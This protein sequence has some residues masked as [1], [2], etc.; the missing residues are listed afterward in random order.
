MWIS[1]VESKFWNTW[2]WGGTWSPNWFP[3]IMCGTWNLPLMPG[4]NSSFNISNQHTGLWMDPQWR[5]NGMCW[6][7]EIYTPHR[8]LL[9]GP[10]DVCR[11]GEIGTREAPLN[12]CRWEMLGGF[13]RINCRGGVLRY[14]VSHWAVCKAAW[15]QRQVD[16]CNSLTKILP[17]VWSLWI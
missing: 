11:G 16:N 1:D 4:N 17:W 8:S 6:S 5:S 9:C 7:T 12:L 2:I 13:P 14:A 10:N 15:L 3:G